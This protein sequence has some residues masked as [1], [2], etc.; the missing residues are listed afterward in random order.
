MVKKTASIVIAIF[1]GSGLYAGEKYNSASDIRITDVQKKILKRNKNYS[2]DKISIKKK[3]N[4]GGAWNMYVF[5]LSVVKNDSKQKFSTPM[6]VFTDGQYQTNSLM[7]IDTFQ[8]YEISELELLKESMRTKEQKSRDLWEQSF[9]LPKKYY[10]KEH[11][12]VGDINAKNKILVL[13]D[14]LCVACIARVPNLIKS[15]KNSKDTA[16]F[17]YDFPLVNMHPT[18]LTIVSAMHLARIDGI[19]DVE[20]KIY[21][22]NFTKLYNVYSSKD[23]AA[24]LKYFNSVMGTKYSMKEISRDKIVDYVEEDMKLGVVVKLKET[25]TILVN[26]SLYNVQQKL[27]HL[28]AKF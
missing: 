24:A 5:D 1:L 7:N 25:P 13:S 4:I 8:R 3:K 23:N 10:N 19:K 9:I 6:I 11:L 21:K 2:L 27:S 15:V 16:L 17:Y 26:G 14:P 22:A 20:I 12:I 28:F 18:S